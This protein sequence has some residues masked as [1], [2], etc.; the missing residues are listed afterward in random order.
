MVLEESSQSRPALKHRSGIVSKETSLQV[1]DEPLRN[2][3][4]PAREEGWGLRGGRVACLVE[5]RLTLRGGCLWVK[6]ELRR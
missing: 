3:D 2:L 1:T 4:Q 6:N 5:R